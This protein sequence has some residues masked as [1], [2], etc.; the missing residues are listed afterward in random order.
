MSEIFFPNL[1]MYIFS[2]INLVISLQLFELPFDVLY[3]IASAPVAQK[4]RAAVS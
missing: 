4:D 1:S 3:H 2:T